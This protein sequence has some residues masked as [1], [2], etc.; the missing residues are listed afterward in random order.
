MEVKTIFKVLIGTIVAMVMG[1]LIVEI[2]N[3]SIAS[4]QIKQLTKIAARNA[5]VLFTQETYKK[6][7]SGGT[8][9]ASNIYRPDG[10]MYCS[11]SF[12]KVGSNLNPDERQIWQSLYM[13]SDFLKF[14]DINGSTPYPE[15]KKI[16]TLDTLYQGLSHG[17]TWGPISVSNIWDADE[18]TIRR[19]NEIARAKLFYENMYTPVNL[20]IPYLDI[21]SGANNRDSV[22]NRMYRWNLTQL[23]T[24]CN[25]SLI[26]QD[27]L[28]NWCVNYKGFKCYT[29]D[30]YYK[31][32]NINNLDYKV[33]DMT[34]A[35]DMSKMRSLLNFSMDGANVD[36]LGGVQ[37]ENKY[38][39]AVGI[40]YNVTIKYE[41]I[42]PLRSIITWLWNRGN[43][44]GYG[45]G[46]GSTSNTWG[47]SG[48]GWNDS[49]NQL[50]TGGGMGTVADS[51][52]DMNQ[53]QNAGLYPASGKL[54]YTLVR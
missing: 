32:C 52:W 10:V 54:V 16:K 53:N 14:C 29:G 23:L 25:S 31:T 24:N 36:T 45:L 41:G 33:Y 15:L 6:Q 21:H 28:G 51:S 2:F 47:K 4:M 42:T 7:G 26:Q 27:A 43:V 46:A 18:A 12:Y 22:V 8:V 49:T 5:C 39:T 13:N 44:E 40:N 11:G 19:A 30:D 9:S 35:S 3:V 38:I 17:S 34:V 50:V 37:D 20:G 48:T 1:S